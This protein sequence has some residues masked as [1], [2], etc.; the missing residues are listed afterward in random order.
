MFTIRLCCLPGLFLLLILFLSSCQNSKSDFAKQAREESMQPIRPGIPE[1]H[2]FW[3]RYSE[4]FIHAPAFNFAPLL[5]SKFYRFIITSKEDKRTYRFD[6]D[7]PWVPLTPV[8]DELPIGRYQLIIKAM[9][10]NEDQS[11]PL[12]GRRAFIKSPSFPGIQNEPAYPY[13]ESGY[14][15]LHDVLH[16]P[17]VQHWLKHKRPDPD[18]P[19]WC[20]PSKIMSSLIAGMI[21]YAKY[22][23]DAEER[24]Q[25][26]RVADIVVDFFMNMAEP[27]GKPLEYWT[28]THWD[29]VDRGDH[30]YF[31]NE[32]MTNVPTAAAEM[33]LDLYEFNK[34]EKHLIAAKRIADTYVKT[35]GKEGTWPLLIDSETGQAKKA[36]KLIPAEVIRLFDRLIDHYDCT[37]YAAPRQRAFDY[38]MENPVKTFNWQAQF[39]DTRPQALYKNLAFREPTVF[40]WILL[41]D[42]DEHPDYIPLAEEILR[43]VEDQFVVWSADDPLIHHHPWFKKEWKWHPKVPSGEPDWFL[44]GVLEQYKFYTPIA[45][46]S[47]ML[48]KAYLKAYERTGKKIY[49]AKA[50]ALANTLTVAQEYH[51]GGEIPTHLR[52]NLPEKNWLNCGI[53]PAI[54]LI[55]HAEKLEEAAG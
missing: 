46:S 13:R 34:E 35:Q 48:F 37:E 16:Q 21:G 29:G 2:H 1:E 44:P 8:W 55:E 12:V 53:Y 24:D 10:S 3:N 26:L 33:L 7:K 11:P 42:S 52:K 54:L 45:R 47:D 32:I 25:A 31:H 6:A 4:R 5:G 38:I 41:D 28:P 51:G 23:P 40:C 39:E 9:M 30:P 18:Y 19:L 14:R 50:V 15:C 49:H 17:K 20:H 22:F 36:D 27:A 43:F